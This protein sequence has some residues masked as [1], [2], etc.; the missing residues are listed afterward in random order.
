MG[1]ITDK[2][3]AELEADPTIKAKSLN[4][5]MTSKGFL[6]R[7]K[8]LTVYG[9]VESANEKDRVMKIVQRQAGD[10]YVVAEK[11]VVIKEPTR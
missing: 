4:L 6:K 3:M 2:I 1:D 10:N 9:T 8:I 5:V 7:G 11:I